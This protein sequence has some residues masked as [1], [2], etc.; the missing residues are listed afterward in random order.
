MGYGLVAIVKDKLKLIDYGALTTPS[1]LP[2]AKRLQRLY[3]GLLDIIRSRKPNEVA[4]EELFFSK[5]A[6][7]ALAVGQARGVAILAA[8]NCGLPVSEY[9]PLAIKRAIAGYGRAQKE[10]VQQMV[11]V[12]LDLHV[13]P[14]PDD[15]ADALALAIC[16]LHHSTAA[17][18]IQEYAVE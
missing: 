14:E 16:H 11:R 10:Q 18:L 2:L 1:G 5:N 7:T 8:A 17:R 12:L 4:V 3:D 6:R 9:T 15:A 13:V